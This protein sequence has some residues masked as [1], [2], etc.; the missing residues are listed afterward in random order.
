MEALYPQTKLKIYFKWSYHMK[1][2]NVIF[3]ALGMILF[4]FYAAEFASPPHVLP[5]Q[6]VTTAIKNLEEIFVKIERT[7]NGKPEL[8]VNDHINYEKSTFVVVAISDKETDG[9]KTY[10]IVTLAYAQPTIFQTI[11][12]ATFDIEAEWDLN[13][14]EWR[15]IPQENGFAAR[16]K[17]NLLT[18]PTKYTAFLLSTMIGALLCYNIWN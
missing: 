7:V 8:A 2:K 4:S 1:I 13:S 5:T 14:H 10:R 9:Q 11:L 17:T 6:E 12:G 3:L 18:T 15:I 16:C